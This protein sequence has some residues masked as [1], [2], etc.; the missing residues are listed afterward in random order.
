MIEARGKTLEEAIQ[1]GLR[2]LNL[3]K[4][5]TDVTVL[6]EASKGF[7]GLGAKPARVL[8]TEKLKRVNKIE[9]ENRIAREM[10][11]RQRSEAEAKKQQAAAREEAAPSRPAERPAPVSVEKP[12]EKPAA[13]PAPQAFT[14]TPPQAPQAPVQAAPPQPQRASQPGPQP[15]GRPQPVQPA[16][17]RPLRPQNAEGGAP[18][19]PR[20]QSAE[21]APRPAAP[22]R[23]KPEEGAPKQQQAQPR[24]RPRPASFRKAPSTGEET[25]V[26]NEAKE[27]LEG[28]LKRMDV[29][30]ELTAFQNE[31]G[32][33]LSAKG[34][35]AGTLIGYRGET[36]DALQ[37]L[38]S[39]KVNK[40]EDDYKRVSLDAEDY[41]AK[42][43]E[44]L[45]KLA[46]RLADKAVKT[47]RKVALEPMNPYERRILHSALQGHP[48]VRTHSEG[49]DPYRR[50]VITPKS[51][52]GSSKP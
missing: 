24:P 23:A 15:Q 17:P 51:G 4:E 8:I 9:E 41:R 18:R 34:P 50:V 48:G 11:I 44:I 35:D 1:N 12:A 52:N 29:D 21:G 6:D 3:T 25:P 36:L 16:Q 19:P 2:Q 46:N 38:V 26:S 14:Q 32:I 10:E 43:E 39:L 5:E 13:A 28:L 7:L 30:I 40:G 37:Y 45:V 49:V 27:Y 31:D 20:Q 33:F 22:G 42:R 47:G